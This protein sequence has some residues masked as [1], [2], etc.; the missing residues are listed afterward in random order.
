MPQI[1]H[2]VLGAT[3]TS[4]PLNRVSKSAEKKFFV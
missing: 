2:Y 4:G 3:S 1:Y